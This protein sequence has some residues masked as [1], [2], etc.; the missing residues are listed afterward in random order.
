MY[1]TSA[2]H[3]TGEDVQSLRQSCRKPKCCSLEFQQAEIFN[4]LTFAKFAEVIRNIS[5]FFKINWLT[6]FF[7]CRLARKLAVYYKFKEKMKLADK[8]GQNI[9]AFQRSLEFLQDRA[10]VE[11]SNLNWLTCALFLSHPA[12]LCMEL[13]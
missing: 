9:L 4:F 12:N 10:Q 8:F 11:F 1:K 3:W 7:H 2:R 5:K 13:N 6:C